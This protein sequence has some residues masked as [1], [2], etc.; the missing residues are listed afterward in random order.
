MKI[1]PSIIWPR[2]WSEHCCR[3]NILPLMYVEHCFVHVFSSSFSSTPPPRSANPGNTSYTTQSPMHHSSI[4]C[5]AIENSVFDHDVTASWERA[6]GACAQCLILIASIN[7]CN[8]NKHHIYRE[9]NTAVH[10]ISRIQP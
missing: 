1:V 2:L 4:C 7:K 8:D 6:A 5:A 9:K 3:F 10:T